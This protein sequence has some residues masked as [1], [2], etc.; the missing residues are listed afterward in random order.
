[1]KSEASFDS[2]CACVC[3]CTGPTLGAVLADVATLSA[4]EVRAGLAAL[5]QRHAHVSGGDLQRV[6]LGL[7]RAVH[8][9]RF[10][11]GVHVAQA[12]PHTSHPGT[13]THTPDGLK[14]LLFNI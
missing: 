3:G 2:R 11:R 7:L 12:Q 6:R 14:Q 4:A 10:P 5:I 13:A 8:P 1:M 9:A